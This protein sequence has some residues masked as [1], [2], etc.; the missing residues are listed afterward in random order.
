MHQFLDRLH[1]HSLKDLL[2]KTGIVRHFDAGEELLRTGQ[3]IKFVPIVLQ[4]SLKVMREDDSGREILLYF[5][6][7]G[8]SCIMT[9]FAVRKNTPSQIRAVVD[10]AAEVL[11]LPVDTVT[12]DLNSYRDWLDFTFALFQQRYEELLGIINDIAFN[13]VDDRLLE[14]LRTRSRLNQSREINA[15]HQQLADELGSVREMVSRLL[16]GF[17]EQGLVRLGREQVEVLDAAGLR[18]LASVT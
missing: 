1:D 16:K 10:E 3:Y 7:P 11:L 15:T 6:R 4:G 12:R 2:V 14:L 18:K 13:R 8:E 9:L 5:I 17:A